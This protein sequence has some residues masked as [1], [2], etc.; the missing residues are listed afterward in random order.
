MK[1]LVCVLSIWIFIKNISY[2]IYEYKENN[3]ISGSVAV[4]V[5]NVICVIFAN[6]VL[7]WA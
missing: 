2:A 1:I 3:N 7:F 4:A 5:F 6:V